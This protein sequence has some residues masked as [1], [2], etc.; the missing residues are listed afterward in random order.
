MFTLSKPYHP[1]IKSKKDCSA[2]NHD[3]EQGRLWGCTKA[4]PGSY[5]FAIIRPHSQHTRQCNPYLC[6]FAFKEH[7]KKRIQKSR[8]IQPSKSTPQLISCP[9]KVERHRNRFGR[10]AYCRIRS[11]A[12]R[13][14]S[15]FFL[16]FPRI[17]PIIF[18]LLLFSCYPHEASKVCS[19]HDTKQ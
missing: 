19:S 2:T 10:T 16:L 11:D 3:R 1:I 5:H 13:E 4:A 7:I 8:E 9:S 12:I 6:S 17:T 15:L 14:F 18:S